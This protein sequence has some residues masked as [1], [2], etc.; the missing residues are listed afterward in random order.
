MGDAAMSADTLDAS[1]CPRC[2][3]RNP[4]DARFCGGCGATLASIE[5]EVPA[6]AEAA[7]PLIG[8]IIADRYRI[9]QL[10]G[11]GGM[12]VVYRVEHV[13]IGK[14]MAMK[15]LRG[16]LAREKNTQKRFQ[17]E[18]EAA[19]RLS[20]PN[21][22]QV[23][24]FGRA[25]GMMYLVMEFL[26]GKDLGQLV[27]DEGH[28]D[29]SRAARLCAQVCASV[30]EAHRQ[31]IVHRDL[32]PENV[33]V[34]PARDGR[35]EVAKVLDF[36]LAKLRDHAGG[37]TVTRAGAIVGTPYYMSPE[38]IRGDDVDARGDIYAIGA[39]LY[40]ACT[41]APPFVAN[42][43]MGVLTKHLTEQLVPPSRRRSNIPLPLAA[44]EII[45]R[46]M[47]KDPHDRYPSADALRDDLLAYLAAEGQR[48]PT[49]HH[50]P[51]ARPG[52]AEVATRR[53][54]DL[55]ERRLRRRGALGNLAM[56]LALGGLAAGAFFG[57]RAWNDRPV[58]PEME[59]EPNDTPETALELP[60]GVVVRGYLGK[61]QSESI[62][63]IDLW[64]IKNAS[65][66]RRYLRAELG[67]IPNIDIV[68]DVFRR[69]NPEPLVSVDT[70]P[71][72]AP[73]RLPAFPFPPGDLILRVRERWIAGV[74]PTEN[75]SD[76]YTLEWSLIDLPSDMEAEINDTVELANALP[77]DDEIR[78][79]LAWERDVDL[80]CAS[81]TPA[82]DVELSGVPGLD[83]ALRA[84]RRNGT[85]VARADEGGV[86]EGERLRVA[87]SP[88][89][90]CVEVRQ[91]TR[92]TQRA[93]GHVQWVLKVS[94][95]S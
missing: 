12:G 72:G 36:G 78:G 70:G 39:M 53:D 62:G 71:V 13:H 40:K 88:E 41:G 10:L 57:W 79:Y 7:D 43:P 67:G 9:C 77:I 2:G 16:E 84:M 26:E 61:R 58:I 68:L 35:A 28:L 38:Q 14:T 51:A 11:R 29:F 30:A 64:I 74:L 42:T 31:G 66:E 45:G 83:L 50:L 4:V 95:G 85:V 15:L 54:V 19:S 69:G 1:P 47:Q 44:D 52:G 81:E 63:D 48:E 17:R 94:R 60:A 59:R 76:T 37:L 5:V 23:F 18:A 49:L 55:Y 32:K 46:A 90:I 56:L 73:E 75:V 82:L 33:M 25:E 65:S 91:G 20:H 24:D 92:S 3:R 21:T 93:N 34:L 80:F 86:G 27:R 89:G 87:A 8:R 22:V 6:P